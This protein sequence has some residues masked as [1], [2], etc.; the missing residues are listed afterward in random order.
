MKTPVV[1]LLSHG[2]ALGV[3]WL[4]FRGLPVTVA[5]PENN[6]PQRTARSSRSSAGEEGRRVLAEMQQGWNTTAKAEYWQAADVA[7]KNQPL[8]SDRILLR[9]PAS[10]HAQSTRPS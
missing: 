2:L 9:L 6:E 8:L 10:L 3:G 7:D 4:A 5:G 1:L